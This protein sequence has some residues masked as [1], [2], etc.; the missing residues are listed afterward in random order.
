MNFIARLLLRALSTCAGR[1][2]ALGAPLPR[3]LESD[4]EVGDVI[5]VKTDEP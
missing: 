4:E 5:E 2:A 3:R 1:S